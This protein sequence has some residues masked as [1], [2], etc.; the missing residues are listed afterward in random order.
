MLDQVN[1]TGANLSDAILMETI[2]L[3]S[4]FDNTD[5]TGADFSDAIL[6]GAQI[7]ELCQKAT[8]VNSQTGIATR[9]SLGCR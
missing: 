2:M 9:D 5:I 6:D 3:R 7:K 1:L 4:T 8:G